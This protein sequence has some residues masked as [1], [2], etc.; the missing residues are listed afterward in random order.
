MREQEFASK[1]LIF[2]CLA[3]SHSYGTNTPSSDIDTRGVFIAPP[4]YSLGIFKRCEQAES[5][6][7]DETIFEIDKFVHLATQCNPN[8]IELLYTPEEN[9]QFI[10]EPFQILRDNAHL[11]L[12]KKAMYSFSGY[13]MSQLKRIKGH[14]KWIN[15]PQKEDPPKLNEFCTVVFSDGRRS[16]LSAEEA[17]VLH[18]KCFLARTKG[19]YCFRIFE[20]DDFKPGIFSADGFNLSSVDISDENLASKNAKYH[21]ILLCDTEEFKQAHKTWKDYWEWKKNRNPVRSKLEEQYGFDGKHASHLVRLMRMCE[22]ILSQGKVIVKRPDAD[23]L[24]GIRNGMYTYEEIINWSDS[25]EKKLKELYETSS[26]RDR[27]D[28][29]GINNLLIDMKLKYWK[30]N[31]LL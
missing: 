12:S 10:D 26:L 2:K 17:T 31:G 21:G 19:E 5:S 7:R 8:I 28:L 25:Q 1:Y 24:L 20:H 29:E 18:D 6:E 14:K 27:P 9:I 4:E 13:A 23:D 22:E 11:I 30:K 16:R 3:G 15:Q